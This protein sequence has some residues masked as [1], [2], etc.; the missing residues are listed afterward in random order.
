[1]KKVILSVVFLFS[2]LS[3]AQATR[4]ELAHKCFF[5]VDNQKTAGKSC[6]SQSKELKLLNQPGAPIQIES[7]CTEIL[8][9][10]TWEDLG[11]PAGF[12]GDQDEGGFYLEAYVTTPDYAAVKGKHISLADT[13]R[14]RFLKCTDFTTMLQ[15]Y[16]TNQAIL[17]AT[18][19][20]SSALWNKISTEIEIK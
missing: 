2:A 17:S 12:M 3:Y 9:I 10:T 1:M 18:C 6:V 14:S 8:D 7:F 20:K 4:I 5:P 11:C 16:S 15:N 19:A 13:E